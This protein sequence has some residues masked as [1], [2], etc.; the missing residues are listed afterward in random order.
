MTSVLQQVE[1]SRSNELA[2]KG[3]ILRLERDIAEIRRDI[4]LLR[5]D[6]GRDIEASKIDVIKWVAGMFIAQ[7]A[8]ILGV[9]FGLLKGPAIPVHPQP[10]VAQE[11]RLPSPVAPNPVA[12]PP[13]R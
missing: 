11:M 12:L 7:T 4:E 5:A 2:T 8:L 10:A 6:V 9:L 1:E 3:D 13:A